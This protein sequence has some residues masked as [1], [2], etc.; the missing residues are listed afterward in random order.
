MCCGL[1]FP[2]HLSICSTSGCWLE[3]VGMSDLDCGL[4]CQL[5]QLDLFSH[6]AQRIKHGPHLW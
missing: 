3:G 5:K 6:L 2:R 4:V 1:P